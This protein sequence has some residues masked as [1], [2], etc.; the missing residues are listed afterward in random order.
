[1][2]PFFKKI[3]IPIGIGCILVA[4]FFGLR[5]VGV[6]LLVNNPVPERVD[7]I[8]TFAGDRYRVIYSRKLME[9]F[10]NAHWLLSDFK[11]GYATLLRKQDFNMSRVTIVDTCVNTISEVKA[12]FHYLESNATVLPPEPVVALVSS[13]YHMRRIQLMVAQQQKVK[14]VTFSYLPVPLEQ[15]NASRDMYRHWWK[16]SGISNVVFSELPKIVYFFFFNRN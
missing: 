7:V 3:R 4:F 11:D 15:Y 8:F 16:Y 13:P 10:K 14:N 1:M 6:W 9:T 5:S 2:K 12:L